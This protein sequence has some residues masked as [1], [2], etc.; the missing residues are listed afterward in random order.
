M[1]S[2]TIATWNVNSV[3]L[4]AQPLIAPFVEQASP[5]VL[6]L[7][8]IKCRTEEFPEKTF[9][10]MGYSHFHV[11]GMK[12]MHG[13]AIASRYPL[14]DLPDED[15]CRA[16][17][18]RHQRVRVKGIEL[19]NF[20]VPA[21]GD[22][23]DPDIN[24]RFAHKLDFLDRMTRYFDRRSNEDADM[25]LVG[26]FNIA[27]HENDVWSHKQLLKVVSHTPVETAGLDAM[28]D[29]G[30]FIDVA[31]ALIPEDE[32]IYTWWS[33]RSRD[34]RASNRGRRLDHIWVSPSLRSQALAAGRN[35]FTI[36]DEERGREKP[37]DHVPVTLTL[38]L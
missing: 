9:R 10:E 20:Y 26:D 16:S 8:E 36:W 5:D 11:R 30:G 17:E 3:R 25:V 15:F 4:R 2:L 28:R 12:G 21:G 19:H 27:P 7:Q 22:E 33:Y 29:A 37:S 1:S 31:R 24:P 23:P 6:C 13:V 34:Y 35:A 14:E 32:K 38:S 18:A